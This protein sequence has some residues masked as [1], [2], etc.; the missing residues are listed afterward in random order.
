M[1]FIPNI[2]NTTSL[3]FDHGKKL[4]LKGLHGQP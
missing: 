2:L 3:K 4:K 1:Q